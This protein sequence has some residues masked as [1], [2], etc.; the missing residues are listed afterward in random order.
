MGLGTLIAVL[1]V[2]GVA[3]WAVNKFGAEFIDAKI[4]K[5]INIVVI[6]AVV[7]WLVSLFIPIN[8]DTVRVGHR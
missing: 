5:I 2:I 3:L 4:L 8:L 6:I 1:I 7:I